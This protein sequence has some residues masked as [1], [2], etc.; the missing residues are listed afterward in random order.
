ML[1]ISFFSLLASLIISVGLIE[2]IGKFLSEPTDIERELHFVTSD[3]YL[4]WKNR[5][6]VAG[7]FESHQHGFAGHVRFDR[8][9]LRATANPL[10][11]TA[12]DYKILL[13]GDSTTAGMEVDDHQ[14]FASQL[15]RRL[16]ETGR[17][18]QIFNAGVRGYGADQSLLRLKE[19]LPQLQPHLVIFMASRFSLQQ[20][21]TMKNWYRP[22]SKPAFALAN[23]EL[24]LLNSPIE[25]M[26][27]EEFAYL[28]YEPSGY[29]IEKGRAKPSGIARFLRKNSIVYGKLDGL[30]YSR[31]LKTPIAAPGGVTEEK[32]QTFLRLVEEMRKLS[33][34]FLMTGFTVAKGGR[35]PE[36]ELF[37]TL[38]TEIRQDFVDIR[39]QFKP[40][41]NYVFGNDGHWNVEGHTQAARALFT[42]LETRLKTP[43]LAT[44]K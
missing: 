4:G 36:Y 17:P 9:G 12:D 39:P 13:I 29:T 42:E 7:I 34:R 3:L 43:R 16:R 14:T 38:A 10:T 22:F 33:P 24:E 15:E 28:K 31:F 25:P 18:V 2:V 23:G 26:D 11:P 32:K 21:T 20:L 8:L 30:Y 37:Q 44:A 35:V 1:K 19:L 6:G 40:G 27:L 5:E 41:V